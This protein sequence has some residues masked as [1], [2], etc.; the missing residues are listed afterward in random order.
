M[1]ILPV[2]FALTT[3][4][5]S[6]MLCQGVPVELIKGSEADPRV[7]NFDDANVVVRPENMTTAMPLV[8]YLPGTGGH[9]ERVE[10]LLQVVA[11]Q[12]YRV[13]GLEYDD[14]PAV[15]QVCPEKPDPA[16]AE[17]FREMR[18]WGTGV[19]KDVSNS[20][21]ESIA[22]R[23]SA[24]LQLLAKRHPNEAWNAYLTSDGKPL[25]SL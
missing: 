25:W 11:G 4:R 18:I 1:K 16:C 19:S 8:I 15:G 14:I 5:A 22:G 7:K 20:P 9:P 3:L 6:L 10:R 17:E 12:G 23:L 24:L 2:L 21:A 13:I